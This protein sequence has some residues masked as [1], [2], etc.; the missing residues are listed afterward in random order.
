MDQL[1][2]AITQLTGALNQQIEQI[3][4]LNNRLTRLETTISPPQNVGSAPAPAPATEAELQEIRKLPDCVRDLQVFEGNPVRY[5]SWIH[6]VESI[7]KDYEIVKEKPIY[8]AILQHIRQKIRGPADTALISYNIFDE[9]WSKIKSCL[10]LHYADKRDLRTLEHELGAL[11]QKNYSID[12][13]YA[14]I[15]HQLS[16]IINKIKTQ[17]YSQETI[18]ALVGSYRNRALD[19]F[20]RG[21]NGELSRMLIIQKPQNLPEAYA[22]CLEIQNLNCRNYSIHPKVSN[23]TITA[24]INQI[25]RPRYQLENK[26][27]QKNL[28]YN[29]RNQIY[30]SGNTGDRRQAPLPIPPPRPTQPKPPIPMDI[31]PS[32]RT[33]QINYMNRPREEYVPKRSNDSANM[34]KKQ[35][36]LFNI[37]AEGNNVEELGNGEEQYYEEQNYEEQRDY[38]EQHS[39]DEQQNFKEA[40]FIEEAYLVY[41]T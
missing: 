18:D 6:S 34:P 8:R 22:S 14:R 32:V 29:E 35:Q 26:L 40:N 5:I 7:L 33:R 4:A 31:D 20:I 36:R 10:S 21:I 13:F 12:Q 23:N 17:D 11:S 27:P 16:L 39:N 1:Q 25:Y 9:D 3:R 38:E 2:N 30:N 24:P 41:H 19:T 37:E 28:A 15:N